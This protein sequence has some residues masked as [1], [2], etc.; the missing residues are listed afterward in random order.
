MLNV[1][2]V[3]RMRKELCD[4]LNTNP[5]EYYKAQARIPYTFGMV[6]TWAMMCDQQS[7]Q[8]SSGTC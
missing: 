5:T 7:Q 6:L 2:Q 3:Q 8:A 1:L 4:Y